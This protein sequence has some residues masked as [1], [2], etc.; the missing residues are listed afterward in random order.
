[1]LIIAMISVGA[2]GIYGMKDANTGFRLLYQDRMV[3]LGDLLEVQRLLLRNRGAVS[4]AV[5]IDDLETTKALAA[6]ITKNAEQLDTSWKEFL[7][8]NLL[9][10][11]K[12]IAQEF[13]IQRD[14]FRSEFLL[15]ARKA[16]AEGDTATARELLL[17][18]DELL[19]APLRESIVKLTDFQSKAGEGEYL[20]SQ[21]TYERMVELAVG[22]I[23]L[24]TVGG[25]LLGWKLVNNLNVGFSKAIK[26]SETIAIG[27]LTSTIEV[28][29]KDEVAQLLVSL[30][31][32]QQSLSDVVQSVHRGA[33]GVATASS[34]IAQGN[35]DLSARTESQASALQ[36]TAASMEELNVTVRQNA[37]NALMANK[38]AINASAV[39]MRGGEAVTQVV[40]T[41]HEIS[42][43]SNKISDIIQVIDSIAFQTNILALNA[44]VEAARAGE[45]GR[46]FAV[47]AAE[48]RALAQRSASA[49]KEIKTLILDS[50]ERVDQGRSLAAQAGS[51]MQEVVSSIRQVTDLVG[52][53][54][55]ASTEQSAGVNQVG[56]AVTQM[57][58]ATQQNAALVE[59]MAAA[60][61][62]LRSQADGLVSAVGV[63]KLSS[64]QGNATPK[65]EMGVSDPGNVAKQQA[66]W[67]IPPQLRA[68]ES[69]TVPKK[70]MGAKNQDGAWEEF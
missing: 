36:E 43:S 56:E 17:T 42:E 54:T 3:A 1:M 52:E 21:S 13:E 60:A 34:Q 67:D 39:A 29:G 48:V 70:L 15:P 19:Y 40:T 22:L 23:L 14:K 24:T 58:Q 26:T 57:D 64:K 63:F 46:G 7:Q 25:A 59:E 68:A 9:P 11:E 28:S 62:G 53:I 30:S 45:Q 20:A 33:E 50:V 65:V 4:R 8:T 32:M 37:D 2:F 41:I 55:A 49:A 69:T 38:L 61:Q 66:S 35:G 6:S 18:K 5:A 47:V 16:M 51:T 27:D 31:K 12:S 10:E 44:A